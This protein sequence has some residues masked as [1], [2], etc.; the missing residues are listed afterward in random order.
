MKNV[1]LI[2]AAI[3]AAWAIPANA[4]PADVVNIDTFR[5][6]E[7][8]SQIEK[9]RTDRTAAIRVAIEQARQS[10]Q[11]SGPIDPYV[12]TGIGQTDGPGGTVFNV[13]G[14]RV[15]ATCR[16]RGMRIY[17]I[18]QKREFKGVTVPD[19]KAALKAKYGQGK[20]ISIQQREG[21]TNVD[22]WMIW[23]QMPTG[24]TGEMV[25]KWTFGNKAMPDASTL[26]PGL[27]AHLET[28][29]PHVD[30]TLARFSPE[31]AADVAACVGASQA[32]ARQ[33]AVGAIK[34]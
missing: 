20:T 2:M 22:Q 18:T 17:A 6:G 7:S 16:A 11:L 19:V 3:V 13:A 23:G 30:V 26:P 15:Y 21:S 32:A 12:G 33:R 1:I 29:G 24:L 27:S 34:F 28:G 9:A 25:E 10:G 4:E 8:A 31:I 5:I 14:V